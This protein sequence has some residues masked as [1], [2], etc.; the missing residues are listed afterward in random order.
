MSH[1]PASNS[2]IAPHHTPYMQTPLPPQQPGL[3]SYDVSQL[4]PRDA[5]S[6]NHGYVDFFNNP[7]SFPFSAFSAF[8]ASQGFAASVNPSHHS[9]I[10]D[11][12]LSNALGPTTIPGPS[13]PQNGSSQYMPTRQAFHATCPCHTCVAHHTLVPAQFGS[14]DPGSALAGQDATGTSAQ[15][16][17]S[18]RRGRTAPYG[19]P[20]VLRAPMQYPGVIDAGLDGLAL[21]TAAAGYARSSKH[22]SPVRNRR[23]RRRTARETPLVRVEDRIEW[24]GRDLLKMTLWFNWSPDAEANAHEPWGELPRVASSAGGGAPNG[25]VPSAPNVGPFRR[26]G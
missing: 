15:A 17:P 20:P 3:P 6:N 1:P 26:S 5:H 11:L 10:D 2:P 7:Y 22:V 24:V 9:Y 12:S 25:A 4:N 14:G 8:D 16:S 23:R 19:R 13:L 18:S 21:P